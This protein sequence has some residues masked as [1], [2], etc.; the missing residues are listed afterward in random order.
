MMRR[1]SLSLHLATPLVGYS[2]TPHLYEP[3]LIDVTLSAP[4]DRMNNVMVQVLLE[5]A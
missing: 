1:F 4:T 2:S 5:P 3:S